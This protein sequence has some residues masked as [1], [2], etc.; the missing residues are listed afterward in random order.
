MTRQVKIVL[1]SRVSARRWAAARH[2]RAT[3]PREHEER[4][5]RL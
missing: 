4:V 3:P 2:D 1:D 5:E